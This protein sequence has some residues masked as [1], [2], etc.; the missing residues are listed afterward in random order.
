MN[1]P[2]E[3]WMV[4]YYRPAMA[5]VYMVICIFD[6]VIA[7]VIFAIMSVKTG[8]VVHWMPLTLQSGGMIH[9]AMGAIIGV[10]AWSRGQEKMQY[11]NNYNKFKE[12]IESAKE[13]DKT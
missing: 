2:G 9:L 11:I 8:N 4:K 5:W 6:F 10:S 3:E 12:M 7:P 13:K 1:I